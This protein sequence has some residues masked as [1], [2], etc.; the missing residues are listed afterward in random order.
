MWFAG[1]HPSSYHRV[2]IHMAA[3]CPG[4]PTPTPREAACP[5]ATELHTGLGQDLFCS[6]PDAR[7][8][9]TNCKYLPLKT[10]SFFQKLSAL[11]QK[12]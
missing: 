10:K 3:A 12:L 2:W 5:E 6:L 1:E 11:L 9:V 7:I 4:V 8:V